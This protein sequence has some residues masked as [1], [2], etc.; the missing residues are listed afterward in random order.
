MVLAF[1]SDPLD[2]EHAN[3]HFYHVCRGVMQKE[4]V[5][6]PPDGE[7]IVCTPEDAGSNWSWRTSRMPI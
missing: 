7:P 2:E 5:F 3:G 6:P 1:V 4:E